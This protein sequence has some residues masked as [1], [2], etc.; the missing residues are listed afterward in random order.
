MAVVSAS[1]G[2]KA[3][4][5]SRLNQTL[6]ALKNAE[7]TEIY[8]ELTQLVQAIG[9]NQNK[10]VKIEARVESLRNFAERIENILSPVSK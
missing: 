6:N 10:A 2:K 8:N 4:T 1:N 9:A 3:D 5:V 7:E